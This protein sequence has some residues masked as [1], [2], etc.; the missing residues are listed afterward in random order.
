MELINLI[1][2]VTLQNGLLNELLDVLERETDQLSEIDLEAMSVS[3]R[4]KEALTDR[5]AKNS[6]L[7]QKTMTEMSVREGLTAGSSLG[8][9]ANRFAARGKWELLG[10]QEELVSTVIRVQQLSSLNREIAECF[11]S[12]VTSSLSL[13][14]RMVNQ[15]NFYGASG[16]YQRRPA[17]AM[18][19]NREV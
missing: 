2:V 8:V 11:A 1:E 10:K 15:S 7:L 13:I 12:S 6:S 5:I 14:T 19:I 3:D 17:G 18:L 16:G 4:A 9:I